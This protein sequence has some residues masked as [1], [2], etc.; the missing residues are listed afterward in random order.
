MTG[1]SFY[2]LAAFMLHRRR[3][4]VWR[5]AVAFCLLLCLTLSVQSQQT[6]VKSHPQHIAIPHGL[7]ILNYYWVSQNKL[8]ATFSQDGNRQ[9]EQLVSRPGENSPFRRLKI[10]HF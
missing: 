2:C 6:A 9:I 7:W 3:V 1:L 10:P 5:L 4:D 8:L